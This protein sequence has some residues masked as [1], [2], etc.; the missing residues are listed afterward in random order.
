MEAREIVQ[1]YDNVSFEEGQ[2]AV[3]LI[4]QG[5]LGEGTQPSSAKFQ[6]LKV[7]SNL[8][9]ISYPFSASVIVVTC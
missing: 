1:Q 3:T 5:H 8:F 6:Q 2:R 9:S 4:G 7:S